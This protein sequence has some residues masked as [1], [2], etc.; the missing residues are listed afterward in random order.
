M[1]LGLQERRLPKH[2]LYR[3]TQRLYAVTSPN[4]VPLAFV[5]ALV[6]VYLVNA[7]L[8]VRWARKAQ[9]VDARRNRYLLAVAALLVYG[10][11][12]YLLAWFVSTIE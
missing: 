2:D 5:V 7:G 12:C 6:F 1:V 11:F 4:S 10:S 8:L 3:A 9:D